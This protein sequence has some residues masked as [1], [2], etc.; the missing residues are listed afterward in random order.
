MAPRKA[1]PSTTEGMITLKSLRL[2]N[3]SLLV[4][5]DTSLITHRWSE[6]AKK[7][8]LNKQMKKMPDE[9]EAKDPQQDFEDSL[10]RLDDGT[11]GFPSIAFKAAAVDAC[12]SIYGI[13]KVAAR[14]AFHVEG[15]FVVIQ[16]SGPTIREDTVR[17][18]GLTADL[19]YRGE[20]KK[21]WAK[22]DVVFN[23][24]VL[25]TEQLLNIF[26]T[27][28]FAVGVGE[29]RPEKNGPHGRFHVADQAE[30]KKLLKGAA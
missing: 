5:G 15:E 30:T 27:A 24:A 7:I 2:E 11:Y 23:A 25:T 18:Q 17:L 14:Q 16:G 13:T 1:A 26:N 29:W 19:R 21:W 12:T 22:I 3:I 4:V 10:Y 8:M 6:K 9:R 20:F 28:G